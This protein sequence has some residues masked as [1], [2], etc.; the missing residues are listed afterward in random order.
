MGKTKID[1][2]IE[3]ELTGLAYDLECMSHG[4][5]F[6]KLRDLHDSARQLQ[7]DMITEWLDE[8]ARG[9]FRDGDGSAIAALAV[10]MTASKIREEFDLRVRQVPGEVDDD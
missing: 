3:K 1:E 10:S 4:N 6:G 5:I 8:R 7:T 2:Q 9:I